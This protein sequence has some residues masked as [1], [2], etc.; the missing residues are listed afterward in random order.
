MK[1]LAIFATLLL[2]ASAFTTSPVAKR[3]TTLHETKADLRTLANDLNPVVKYYD[4]WGLSE[5]NLWGSTEEQVR[6]HENEAQ[7]GTKCR[8]RSILFT[9][10]NRK[11]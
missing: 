7:R 8:A 9:A 11:S 4:P 1:L 3:S 10:V 6:L 2:S 5:A